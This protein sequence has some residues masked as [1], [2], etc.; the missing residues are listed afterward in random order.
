MF[1]LQDNNVYLIK[2]YFAFKPINLAIHLLQYR[3]LQ[4]FQKYFW[5]LNFYK[6]LE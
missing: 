2:T 1:K 5:C 6:V 4:V 3:L